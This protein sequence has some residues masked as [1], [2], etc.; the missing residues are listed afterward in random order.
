[1]ANTS[2]LPPEGWYPDRPNATRLRHWNGTGWTNEFR[3]IVAAP[4]AEPTPAA[5]PEPVRETTDQARSRR[6]LRA[7]VGSLVHGEPDTPPAGVAAVAPVSQP[8]PV[9]PLVRAPEPEPAP[10]PA[11]TPEPEPEPEPKPE[12]APAPQPAPKP[13]PDV[14]LSSVDRA[15][16]AGGYPPI[17]EQTWQESFAE[18]AQAPSGSSH[19]LAG[20]LF[21]TSPLWIG[22][23][24][25]AGM[26]VLAIVNPLLVQGGLALVGF[27]MTFLLARQ[28]V[29]NLTERGFR[30]PSVWWVLLPF[31]YFVVRMGKVG[32]RGLGM[33]VTYLLS[34]VALV[35]LLYVAFIGNPALLSLITPSMPA[36]S[37]AIPTPVA[38]LSDQERNNLL[39]P[40]GVEAQL[41]VD[42]AKTFDVGSIDCVPFPSTDVAATTTCVVV[43]DGVT[44]N[45]GLEVTPN[46]PSTAFVV[47]GMLPAG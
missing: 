16:A 28:D 37:T 23:L 40:D 26:T 22:A 29:R 46:E 33:L 7:Q 36:T 39:T 21:A 5:A 47:T 6:E 44:Y 34:F 9:A 14:R 15:R 11:P 19:S 24:L 12:P 8:V 1:M 31:L 3:P 38:T 41:R 43:L 42:L 13:E 32:V 17:R 4:T 27:A 20:W 45:A 18:K 10:R 25:I 30:A 2:G 35:G